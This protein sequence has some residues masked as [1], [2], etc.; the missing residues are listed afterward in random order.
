MKQACE[1]LFVLHNPNW[2]VDEQ[3]YVRNLDNYLV[4]GWLR[5]LYEVSNE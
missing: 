5:R 3:E 1:R 2:E 4:Y